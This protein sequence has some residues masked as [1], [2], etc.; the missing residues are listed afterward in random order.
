MI[1]PEKQ[2]YDQYTALDY[3]WIT[4]ILQEK[5]DDAMSMLEEDCLIYGGAIRDILADL[6]IS[7]DL[8]VAVPKKLYN[9]ISGKFSNSTRWENDSHL[10]QHQGSGMPTTSKKVISRIRTYHNMNK[11]SVQLIAPELNVSQKMQGLDAGAIDIVQNVDIICCGIMSDI[12]GIVYEVIPGA[13]EDCKNKIL[14]FN[15]KIKATQTSIVRLKKRIIKLEKRGW[16]SKIDLSKVKV[17]EDRPMTE[18]KL[19]TS[20]KMFG[21]IKF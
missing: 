12:F 14:R 15:H 6:P 17:V 10:P 8:D 1:V 16:K 9:H 11:D 7:G 4:D 3:S 21:R 13:I 5:F 19:I 20:A 2:S 18:D